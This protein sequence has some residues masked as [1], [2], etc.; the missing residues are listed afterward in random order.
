[1]TTAAPRTGVQT[2]RI[3]IAIDYPQGGLRFDWAFIALSMLFIAGLWVDGW[4]H[5]H[6]QVDGSFFTPWHLLFYIAFGLIAMFVGFNHWRNIMRGYAF[7]RALPIGY[8][9]ALVGVAIFALG[10]L[11]DMVWHT[12]F[13]IESGSE[14]LTSPSHIVLVVGMVLIVTS[15]IRAAWQRYRHGESPSWLALAPTL[16]GIT[17]FLSLLAFFTTY[18]HPLMY[19]AAAYGASRMQSTQDLGVISVLVQAAFI[20]GVVVLLTARWRLPFGAFTLILGLNTA[21]IVILSDMPFFV[22]CALLTGLIADTVAWFLKPSLENIRRFHAFAFFLPALYFMLYF[23]A[24]EFRIGIGWS[25]HVWTGAIVLAGI[26]GVLISHLVAASR[27]PES[28]P[29]A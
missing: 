22:I 4:A 25:I 15:P 7:T 13:G 8:W 28:S 11:G 1:M 23:L 26:V 24:I 10:G 3:N 20:A 16:M 19:P 9:Y 5:F 6:G 29:T 27:R 17:L 14:A 12:L 2:P 18:A 21:M